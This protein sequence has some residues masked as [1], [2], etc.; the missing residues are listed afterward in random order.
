M[1]VNCSL[2][3]WLCIMCSR[4]V[5]QQ[6][7]PKHLNVYCTIQ[8]SEKL[9]D[10]NWYSASTTDYKNSSSYYLMAHDSLYDR[11][12]FFPNVFEVRLWAEQT[13]IIVLYHHSF[14]W[15]RVLRSVGGA[16]D[17]SSE[18]AQKVVVVVVQVYLLDHMMSERYLESPGP[19]IQVQNHSIYLPCKVIGSVRI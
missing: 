7:P 16:N 18:W 10:W 14:C 17:G 9:F 11:F 8:I 13:V 4:K 12:E 3:P 15:P 5:I 6:S 1:K 19:T 2:Q